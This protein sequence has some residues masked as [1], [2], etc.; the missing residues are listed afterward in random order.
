M[1]FATDTCF[2]MHIREIYEEI[3]IDLRPTINHFLWGVTN[4][5]Q[6]EMIH[7]RLGTFIPFSE[8]NLIPIDMS[9]FGKF[10]TLN[11]FLKEYDN[12]DQTL[13]Y[14]CQ[15]DKNILL[16]DDGGLYLE[17]QSYNIDVLDLPQFC[18]YLIRDGLLPKK[19]INLLFK[20]WEIN[21]YYDE[22]KIQRYKK[23]VIHISEFKRD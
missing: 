14:S 7:F 19:K 20:F 9:D 8:A 6:K 3:H 13:L 10:L 23:E 16:T 4:E 11:S 1:Q 17:A 2:W 15:R 12:A 21:K 18:I 5:V 22:K